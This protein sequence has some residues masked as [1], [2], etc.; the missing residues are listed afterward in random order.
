[1]SP[2]RTVRISAPGTDSAVGGGVG[3]EIAPENE[4]WPLGE[5]CAQHVVMGERSLGP[6]RPPNGDRDA[7]G[8]D[9]EGDERREPAPAAL[10][11]PGLPVRLDPRVPH[12]RSSRE[13]WSPR[14]ERWA[15]AGAE[16]SALA[17]PLD[18]WRGG[19][20]AWRGPTRTQAALTFRGGSVI[21]RAAFE[22]YRTTR[23]DRR[24]WANRRC[25]FF[26]TIAEHGPMPHL[27]ADGRTGDDFRETH[28]SAQQARAQAP[29][30]LPRPPR[31]RRGPQGPGG[32]S[33]AW[34]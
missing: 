3:G 18:P 1:M 31:H 13:A 14:R 6:H 22:R 30:R 21:S 9:R 20:T 27:G 32:A 16:A 25:C 5:R 4:R 17:T 26:G 10:S 7:D 11:A 15:F 33:R 19:G 12:S 28:L 24:R 23:E 2:P 8:D 34:P 29:P